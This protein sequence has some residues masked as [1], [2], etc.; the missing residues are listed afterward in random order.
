MTDDVKEF[1]IG[2]TAAVAIVALLC[3]FG[4]KCNGEVQRVEAA[5]RDACI[6]SGGT[7]IAG[8]SCVARQVVQP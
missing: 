8:G 4:S 7:W 2:A 1:G 5:S 3:V 6:R